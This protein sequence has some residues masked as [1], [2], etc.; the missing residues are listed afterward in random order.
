MEL[1]LYKSGDSRTIR[2]PDQLYFS[3]IGFHNEWLP[4]EFI[5]DILGE[6]FFNLFIKKGFTTILLTFFRSN[7]EVPSMDLG[8]KYDC[9]YKTFL[10]SNSLG[11]S[12][13]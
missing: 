2:V 13:L 10:P 8:L 6:I 3:F 5:N 7:F 4:I 9:E 1:L 11:M 12:F